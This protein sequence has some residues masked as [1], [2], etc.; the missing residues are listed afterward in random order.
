M[1]QLLQKK[2]IYQVDV[3]ADTPDAWQREVQNTRDKYGRYFKNEDEFL[4]FSMLPISRDE[5][6]MKLLLALKDEEERERELKDCAGVH[7][8]TKEHRQRCLSCVLVERKGEPL[9]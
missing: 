5:D 7:G 8:Q 3:P 1:E 9:Y 2:R 6:R 4:F